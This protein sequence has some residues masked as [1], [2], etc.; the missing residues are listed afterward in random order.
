MVII[1]T[2]AI[3]AGIDDENDASKTTQAVA[4]VMLLAQNTNAPIIIIH[5]SRKRGGSNGEAIRGSGAIL[6]TVDISLELKRLQGST[7]DERHL[8]M[9]TRM[10]SPERYLLSFDRETRH[11]TVEDAKDR[12]DIGIEEMLDGIPTTGSGVDREWLANHWGITETRKRIIHLVN[13]GRMRERKPEKR[14]PGNKVLYWA[15]PP[16]DTTPHFEDED[17]GEDDD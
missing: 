2:L 10:G 11:Y 7:T 1:D 12:E 16:V 8:D 17:G 9:V 3:W 6:A 13:I 4:K 14:G 5:H 15:I